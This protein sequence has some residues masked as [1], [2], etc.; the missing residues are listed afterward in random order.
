MFGTS[1]IDSSQNTDH[2]R[3]R[4]KTEDEKEQR[5]IERVLRN[6]AAAHSSRE[7]KRKE[8]EGLES[9]KHVIARENVMLKTQNEQLSEQ[10]A[11]LSAE[12]AAFRQMMGQSLPTAAPIVPSPVL[13]T[14][15]QQPALQ[16]KQELDE[17][18][19]SAPPPQATV[20]PRDSSLS[21]PSDSPVLQPT[22]SA[23]DMTQH[24]AEMLCDLQCQ[25]EAPKP[26]DSS[27]LEFLSSLSMLNQVL[28]LTMAS[29]TYSLLT[30]PLLQ[31][32]SSLK[33]GSPL[34]LPTATPWSSMLLFPLIR[35]LISTPRNPLKTA[36]ASAST[37]AI[38]P[39]F[40]FTL[41]QRLLACSPALARPLR[42][43]TGRALQLMS[44]DGQA[45]R[46][47]SLHLLSSDEDARAEFNSLMTMMFAIDSILKKSPGSQP[48]DSNHRSRL[49][50]IPSHNDEEQSGD[51][52]YQ[53]RELC[54]ALDEFFE[55][56]DRHRVGSKGDSYRRSDSTVKEVGGKWI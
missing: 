17:L 12:M 54:V 50:S 25:S 5:R 26:W 35:W 55:K 27:H 32:F 41:L 13:S 33:T 2:R 37:T 16:V 43:A 18:E 24:P 7:R 39:T 42:A 30:Q 44:D 6:R 19:F 36:S 52:S 3:K 1:H 34:S 47:G 48:S 49:S 22:A 46:M 15:S 31:I 56:D 20:D 8:V 45:M 38:K 23:S 21:S 28:F 10:V 51:P 14:S 29:T 11:R 4:A 53:V 9:E 40:R